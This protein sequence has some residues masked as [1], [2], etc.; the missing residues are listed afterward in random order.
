[1]SSVRR[2]ARAHLEAVTYSCVANT[3]ITCAV[4]VRFVATCCSLHPTQANATL[5]TIRSM[6]KLAAEAMRA[7][8]PAALHLHPLRP[9]SSVLRPSIPPGPRRRTSSS[10]SGAGELHMHML[11]SPAPS[12]MSTGP[13]GRPWP[14]AASWRRSRMHRG[15]AT[16]FPPIDRGNL[17][18]EED[19]ASSVVLP[20]AARRGTAARIPPHP[21]SSRSDPPVRVCLR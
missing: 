18:E 14:Q 7:I 4:T 6:S 13:F 5:S 9:A 3:P 1:M 20:G 8:S 12:P 19:T 21:S 11:S 2:F 15:T 17:S 10:C 16:P